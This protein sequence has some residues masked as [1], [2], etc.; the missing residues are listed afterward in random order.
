MQPTFHLHRYH[1]LIFFGRLAHYKSHNCTTRAISSITV[2]ST[3]TGAMMSSPCTP[4][5]HPALD[6]FRNGKHA[7]PH[8]CWRQVVQIGRGKRRCIDERRI[9]RLGQ[10]WYMRRGE[11]SWDGAIRTP[12]KGHLV[13]VEVPYQKE[14][15]RDG[16]G[17]KRR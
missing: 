1:R 16:K 6:A 12:G 15:Q 11:R 7:K 9:S 3:I 8:S 5:E 10:V 2:T 14:R 17:S 4:D 13:W